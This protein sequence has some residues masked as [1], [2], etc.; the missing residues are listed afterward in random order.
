[1]RR[2]H[3]LLGIALLGAS[4]QVAAEE[5]SP[6]ANDASAE[7]TSFSQA[8]RL[9]WMTDQLASVS[10][11]MSIRYH[12][13]RGGSLEPGF[14]DEVTFTISEIK[15]DGMKAAALNFFTGE[16]NFPIP[17][18]EA[19]NVNPVLGVYLQGD[20]YE[21][22][23]LTDERGS[24]KERWRYFH[25]QIKHAISNGA[26]IESV[27][28]EF[29]GQTYKGHH[30]VFHPF[31]NDPHRA[32]FEDFAD[33]RY[34]VMLSDELPGYLYQIETVVPGE[35]KNFDNPLVLERLT[36]T[37]VGPAAEG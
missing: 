37:S 8:E 11:P 16:R 15:E 31:E 1:M 27:D 34:S 23:R 13:I 33:K 3:R 29:N 36:L 5:A 25:R 26:N 4:I 19:T 35:G 22:N 14:E 9:M 24:A 18:V 30:I 2:I 32:E 6:A 17:P 20:V 12:F 10:E 7:A 28:I 21:M